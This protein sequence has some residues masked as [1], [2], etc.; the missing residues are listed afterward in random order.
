VRLEQVLSSKAFE[1]LKKELPDDKKDPDKD[2]ERLLGV[3][4]SS[5]SQLIVGG[6]F[7][8]GNEEFLIVA[9][10]H[11]AIV[12]G[13]IVQT[14]KNAKY[15][16]E[17]VGNYTLYKGTFDQF[18]VVDSKTVVFAVFQK[19]DTLKKVLERDQKADLSEAMQAALKHTDFSRTAAVA[20][21]FKEIRSKFKPG[22]MFGMAGSFMPSPTEMVDVDDVDGF[23][24]SAQVGSDIKITATAVCKDSDSAADVRKLADGVVVMA[25]KI[26]VVPKELQDI[27]ATWDSSSSGAKM[28]GSL[29]IKVE[30]VIKITKEAGKPASAS[31]KKVGT[32][33]NGG[34]D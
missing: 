34:G 28:T 13:D 32:A 12:A 23:S 26:K 19:P 1:E 10:T 14:K 20:V 8:S 29:T 25:K 21:N 22:G 16:E 18:C 31:F 24:L 4:A 11:K 17:T 5:I 9:K 27:L 7:V 3:P 2:F 15:D 6:T 33:I 30:P